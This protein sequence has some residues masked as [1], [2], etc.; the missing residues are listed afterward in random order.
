M[1]ATIRSPNAYFRT[2]FNVRDAT[3]P[4]RVRSVTVTD[5]SVRD[6]SVSALD[7]MTV[8]LS[9]EVFIQPSELLL[10]SKTVVSS[11]P[12]AIRVMCTCVAV[13]ALGLETRQTVCG[14]PVTV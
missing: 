9:G 10:Y 12:P 6:R 2:R 8:A 7:E 1:E 11:T 5:F 13:P 4:V 14:F 3:V